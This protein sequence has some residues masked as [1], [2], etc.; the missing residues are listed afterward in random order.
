MPAPFRYR[1]EDVLVHRGSMCFLSRL[2]ACDAQRLHAQ[3]E[4]HADSYGV[5]DRQLPSWIGIE[6]MAQGA[7][8]WAGVARRDKG[9]APTIGLLVGTRRLRCFRPYFAVGECVDVHCLP[10]LTGEDALVVFDCWLEVAGQRRVEAAIKAYQPDDI[11]R[12]LEHA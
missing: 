4:I 10:L 6:Y 7:S 9:L 8:A 1:P 12:F 2:V 5:A 11:D 3:V